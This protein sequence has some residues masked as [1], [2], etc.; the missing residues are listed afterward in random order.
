MTPTKALFL[1][2]I[3]V[4]SVALADDTGLLTAQGFGTVDAE[5]YKGPQAK[6]LA[7]RAAVVDGRRNLLEVIDGVRITSG[8]TV[9]DL[10]LESDLI[11]TRVKGMLQGAFVTSENLYEDSGS[12]I[13]EVEMAICMTGGPKACVSK[14]T[15]AQLMQPEL[16]APAPSAMFMADNAVLSDGQSSEESSAASALAAAASTGLIVDVTAQDFSPMLDVR[17]RTKDGK[18]LY[19]PGHVKSGSDWLHWAKSVD[20]ARE[21]TDIVGSAPL[22]VAVESMGAS[23][24]LVVSQDIAIDI[25]QKN[26]KGGD[27]LNQGKVIFVVK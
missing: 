26:V 25:F 22:V 9:K 18:E 24:E 16:V 23:S 10:T 19:G 17:V 4:P 15:L 2:A 14:P 12:W 27:F 11:G 3:I 13:A 21:L 6:M 8:T 1:L 5:R 20:S 7:R